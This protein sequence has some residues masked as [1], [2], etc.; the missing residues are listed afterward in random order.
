MNVE[1]KHKRNE[2]TTYVE[3]IPKNQHHLHT[4]LFRSDILSTRAAGWKKELL[5]YEIVFIEYFL[6]EEIK[7]NGYEL[8]GEKI[9]DIKCFL[10]FLELLM[11]FLKLYG[12]KVV[13]KIQRRRKRAQIGVPEKLSRGENPPHA[14]GL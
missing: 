5:D 8:C 6:A 7:L 4:N 14:A 3:R 12:A 10:R 1:Y 2:H 13:A 9:R 11:L